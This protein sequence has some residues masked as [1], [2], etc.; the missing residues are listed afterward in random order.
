MGATLSEIRRLRC[1]PEEVISIFAG[2][3]RKIGAGTTCIGGKIGFRVH[4]RLG[5]IWILDLSTAGGAWQT[6]ADAAALAGCSTRIYAF[7]P[8]FAAI[9]MAP[10]VI[11]DLLETGLFVVEGDKNKL[12]RLASLLRRDGGSN[13][14]ALRA[15]S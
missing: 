8:E 5:G 2:L 11:E 4:G 14:I 12:G 1:P 10:E 6:E 15:E 9:L 7:A 3:I 13:V